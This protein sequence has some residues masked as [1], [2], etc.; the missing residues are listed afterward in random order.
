MDKLLD[1]KKIPPVMEREIEGTWGALQIR[2]EDCIGL[3]EQQRQDLSP[4]DP[5][6]FADALEEINAF[7]N[8]TYTKRN[9]LDDLLIQKESWKIY[10]VDFSESFSPD[11]DLLPK[12]K[13]TRCSK[14]LF[15][16]L[17]DLSDEVIE[18]MLG[19]YLNDEE[20]SALLSRK[21]LIVKTIEKLIAEHGEEAILF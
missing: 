12:Q 7:E 1:F 8:L 20:M 14:K 3:D 18:S 10:R 15:Q 21:A 6:A 13:I 5:Q 11:P 2:V 17:K 4:P 9:E 16:N 19:N